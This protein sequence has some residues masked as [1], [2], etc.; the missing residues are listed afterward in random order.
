MKPATN[1]I[2]ALARLQRLAL[3]AAGV[4]L[5]TLAIG[6]VVQPA[7]A[8]G[9][10]LAGAV[11]TMALALGG[12]VLFALLAVTNAGWGVVC[13]RV[14]EGFASYLGV[15]A[16]LM[17]ALLPGLPALYEWARPEAAADH[18]LRG[19]AAFLNAPFF[20]VRMVV[21]VSVWALFAR[22]LRGLSR[23]QDSA[24]G[25]RAIALTRAQV[26]WS[27]GFLVVAAVTWCLASFDWL[28]SLEPHW[29]STIF[30]LY[31]VAALLASATAAVTIASILLRR[32]GLLPQL[33]PA[34]LHDLGKL[35]FGFA[36]LWA[37]QWLSQFLLIW[38]ANLPEETSYYLAR[39][40]GGWAPVFWS[41]VVLN[42]A[43]PFFLLL[44]RAAKRSETHL[45]R[46]GAIMLAGRWLDLWLQITP[47][48]FAERPWP[49]LLELAGTIGPLG[50]FVWTVSRTF[51]K[52][53]LIAKGDPFLAESLH[54]SHP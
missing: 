22:K 23:A 46:V 29:F 25:E 33:G 34:H 26:K 21:L 6:A 37:Y 13:K 41:N 24:T 27:A 12:L 43:L 49:G 5:T 19:K 42:W 11:L 31:H 44:P 32:A 47:P 45:L 36:T 8:L 7:R 18:L 9:N 35:M 3:A 16:V 17:L 38:Y 15:G 30:G 40:H 48:G 54:L 28:M 1:T 14:L 50:L 51:A 52:V 20:A 10:L 39:W 4:G 53:P 2:D